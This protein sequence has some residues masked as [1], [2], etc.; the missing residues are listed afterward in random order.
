MKAKAIGLILL[1]AFGQTAFAKDLRLKPTAHVPEGF[2]RLSQLVVDIKEADLY[3][4]VF[5]G[6]AEQRKIST[7]YIKERLRRRGFITV[8][9]VTTTGS[10]SVQVLLLDAE[11]AEAHPNALAAPQVHD[12]ATKQSSPQRLKDLKKSSYEY[13]KLKS[14]IRR[15]TLLSP[16]MVESTTEHRYI[17]EAFLQA[18]DLIGYQLERSLPKGAIVTRRDTSIPPAIE[19][20]ATV[21]VIFKLPG[22]EISGIAKT[23]GE[24][25]I[26]DTIEVRRQGETLKGTIIDPHTVLI[27]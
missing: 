3:K 2:L 8:H 10:P 17:E 9:P 23:I 24:G 5:L 20:G 21:K 27:Q 11:S 15:G 12:N 6:K 7:A 19:R 14:S 16:E 25:K 4:N 13:L 26:G 22:I 1:F 18:E